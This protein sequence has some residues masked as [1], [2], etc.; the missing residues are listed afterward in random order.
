MTP[1]H[2]A[3]PICILFIS[4][5]L[6]LASNV[7][8][9]ASDPF[10]T[11]PVSVTLNE[12]TPEVTSLTIQI[13]NFTIQP[14]EIEDESFDLITLGIEPTISL[15]G[16]PD[17]PFVARCILV[18]PQSDIRLELGNIVSHI[19]HNVQPVIAPRE[20][21]GEF[22][23]VGES[24][25]FQE[26][27]GFY[28]PDPLVVSEP[29]IIRGNRLV[30]FR[31]YPVQYN[32]STGETR[33]IDNID[34]SL[35]YEGIGEN[36]VVD[37]DRPRPSLNAHRA[38]SQ[39]VENPPPELNRDDVQSGSYLYIVPE[40]RDIELTIQPLIEWRRRQG[41]RVAVEYVDNNAGANTIH[42]LIEEY[43]ESD[44]PVEF[45]TLVGDA[46][47]DIS[48]GVSNNFGDNDYSCMEGNDHLAD[49][50]IGRISCND[51]EQ[52]DR[53]VNKL[54][55]YEADP[56]MDE[57]DWFRQGAVTAGASANGM[58]TVLL[59]RY[60]RR[61]LLNI[62]FTEVRHW[63]HNEDGNLSRNNAYITDCMEWGISI[64][65]HRDY[66]GGALDRNVIF[67]LP[68]RFGRWPAV[69]AISCGVGSFTGNN[70]GYTEAFFKARGGGIGAVGS[71]GLTYVQYN[72]IVA[73][74]IWKG[75]YK[76]KLYAFGW[77]LNTGKYE[78]WRA[79][80]GFDGRYATYLDQNNLIGDS[81]THI[82]TS[83]PRLITA[84]HPE[85]FQTGASRFT[86]HVAD[87]EEETPEPDALVCLYKP[88]ELH[89]TRYTDEDGFADFYI[90][91]DALTEGLLMVT[92]TKHNVK[93]YLADL[94][95][96][97]PDFYLG[98]SG[99][100]A[101]DDD[102]GESEGNDDGIVNPGEII[103]LTVEF[104]NFGDLVPE[105]VVTFSLESLSPW[106]EVVS[107]PVEFDRAPASGRSD[108][109]RFILEV[110]SA[111]PDQ[112]RLE[113][114]A[115]ISVGDNQW[116]S[117]TEVVV[118]APKIEISNLIFHDGE[119]NPGDRRWLD[120]VIRNS[121]HKALESF[122]AV[123]SSGNE[124]V[125]A[126]VPQ[127]EYGRIDVD[128][129]G[130]VEGQLFR[131]DAH[132]FTIPGIRVPL[133]ITIET[134]SSFRDTARTMITV[135]EKD[136]GDPLGPDDYGYICFDSGD[137]EWE[138]AP[139][140]DWVEIDP[141]ED[142]NDFDG[143]ALRRLD[144]SSVA[145][146]LPFEFKY[147][148]EVF[149]QIT[150]CSNGWA[151]F[152]DQS[153]LGDF[154]NRRIAQAEGPNAQLCAW[155]DNLSLSGQSAILIYH[156][157]EGGRFIIEW[158]NLQRL[159]GQARETFEIILYDP[160]VHPTSTGDGMILFQYK[161]VENENAPARN[162]TPFCTIGISNLDDS[163]GI[164]YTYW[165]TY[166]PG[167]REI[168]S[169]M[170]L[171]F[172][173]RTDYRCGVL[174]GTITDAE[175]LEPVPGTE[176]TTTR[177][178]WAE[179][180]ETG[181]YIIDNILVDEDYSITASA[182]GWNDSTLTGFEIVEEE[183]LTVNFEL[184][185][186]EIVPSAEELNGELPVDE[187]E[188]IDFNIA[189]TG[190]GPLTWRVERH[191]RGDADTEPWEFR[192]RYDIS[193]VL[194]DT[195]LMGVVFLDDQFFISG[196][197]GNDPN[198]IYVL[199]REGELVRSFEQPGENGAYGMRDL[200]WDGE[201]LWGAGSRTIRG[202]TLDGEQVIEFEGVYNP[203]T[204]AA[205]DPERS[206][207]WVSGTTTDI[208]GYD[209]DGNRVAELSR[210]NM[211]VYG[212]A[213]YPDDDDGYPLYI[214]H[215]TREGN[216]FVH[217]MNPDDG[218]TLF[219]ACIDP[220]GDGRPEGVYIT[221][222]LDIYS[223]V[224]VRIIND[225]SD[226]WIE[227][228]QVEGRKEWMQLDRY[229]GTLNSG[230]VQPFTLTLDAT[231]LPNALFEGDLVFYHNAL[232]G[233]TQIAVS[234]AVT[235]EIGQ[236]TERILNLNDGWNMVSLNIVP[237]EDDVVELTQP[238]VD[239]ELLVLM[240]NNLGQF[241]R[242]D[243]GFNNIPGWEFTDGYQMSVTE[244]CE[245]MVRGIPVP[246]DEPIQ[247]ND[248]WN[249]KAYFPR[250]AVDAITAL[251]GIQDQ[252]IIAKDVAGRFYVPEYGFSS[253]GNLREGQGYQYKLRESIE[254]I[255][256]IGDV[257]GSS[258]PALRNPEHFIVSPL[259]YE[260]STFGDGIERG[261]SN[262]SILAIGDVKLAGWEIGVFERSELLVGAGRFDSQGRCGIAVWGDDP[263][264]K[265]VD[266]MLEGDKL[267][268]LLWDGTCEYNISIEPLEGESTWS[269]DGLLI[270]R[271]ILN[272]QIPLE[273]GIHR[274]YPNPFNSNVHLS[275]SILETG[276]VT[277]QIFDLTGRET[278]TLTSSEHLAGNYT[279]TW[280]A[281]VFTSGLYIAQ[282]KQDDHVAF[283][284]LMLVK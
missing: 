135:G 267:V 278:A 263:Y 128:E 16:F 53:A 113:L 88:G 51:L 197:N 68:N 75:I 48:L 244:A 233:E 151:A 213:F 245:L 96:V 178:F 61:E 102:D 146:E 283:T 164:E 228:R 150:I 65:H 262:M 188:E 207:L 273:F 264:T 276:H 25:A 280:D 265:P 142:N 58:S 182:Q 94:E 270:G 125:R 77:G 19:D 37:P 147:Y 43:Y 231:G 83:T 234:L 103:E 116:A 218:D 203:N 199:N 249:L 4:I 39:L 154:R 184:L 149:N 41:H 163:D 241:Y 133:T 11:A 101:D 35:I 269:P 185:H 49:L 230:S 141:D 45:V 177:G 127:A 248:G 86:V 152:G 216:H 250:R 252:L 31:F 260:H 21:N 120:V 277:I 242:P 221:N 208:V 148:G 266:G 243:Q 219:V 118:D 202:F 122:T 30:N 50:A 78:I 66:A 195:R 281:S 157:D 76:D 166:P 169:E 131:V 179:V 38:V 209:R 3:R 217:K 238:L 205:W 64:Y 130:P 171:L 93:A 272:D 114:A 247:L 59:A 22:E 10:E 156:D 55:S 109:G 183:T 81:G 46:G 258:P 175:T 204:N 176:I 95:V 240:K 256:N 70:D 29:A 275:Y 132:P 138:Y 17:L 158:N 181:Y 224:M 144:D 40:I 110:H 200:T 20:I 211:R 254:L 174:N 225:G 136:V 119:L 189:N 47:G 261:G 90:E 232:G 165:N 222:Q 215:R 253:M 193:E 274:A 124:S 187:T 80:H 259:P 82:W 79:Y 7:F 255:Y 229:E 54:T 72:N 153:E 143:T 105:G 123:L 134:E 33:F 27:E 210:C 32:R 126:L 18:P 12:D 100:S 167:A 1:L 198:M 28:P 271:P 112:A 246:A 111:C 170:A 206:L 74:G 282:L 196:P 13:D 194:D 8:S 239:A 5:G 180:D 235:E 223:W 214:L 117:M 168:E 14:I 115:Q 162:D 71:S 106:A 42:D 36:I 121:G 191:L 6:F 139:E 67:D 155:W 89:L 63:Y 34:F 140:Y 192:Q 227:I 160:E 172:V 56:Y 9:A 44:D 129:V 92:V 237:E 284:K 52:L 26:Y 23:P 212:L 236:V 57:P 190:N 91:P 268:F 145:V 108:I 99:F 73:G 201:L 97:E 62:G 98:V 257:V 251:E 85:E 60:V 15:E 220:E 87:E 84:D 69:V 226:D 137:E 107:D 279:L 159:S 173:T 161:D 2:L 186:P 104:T 24:T